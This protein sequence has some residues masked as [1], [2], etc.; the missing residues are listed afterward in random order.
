MENLF[1]KITAILIFQL[2]VI[3]I[4]SQS[5]DTLDK[6]YTRYYYHDGELRSEGVIE[7]GKPNGY[8]KSYYQNKVVKSEG[9]RINFKLEGLWVFY[10]IDGDTIEKINYHRDKKNGYDFKYQ[11][12][13]IDG[14]KT[15]ILKSKE[16]FVKDKKQNK[17]Y[18]Y[19]DDGS[20]YQIVNYKNNFKNG[21]TREFDKNGNI[22][23]VYTYKNGILIKKENINRF[24]HNG[25]K[26]GLW[27]DYFSNDRIKYEATYL[28]DKLHGYYKEWNIKGQLIKNVKY[29]NGEIVIDNSKKKEKLKIKKRYYDNGKIKYKGSYRDTIPVGIHRKYDESGKIAASDIY[30]DFGNLISNGIVDDEGIY[31]GKF[32]NYYLSGEKKSEGNYLKGLKDGKWIFYYKSGEIEQEGYFRKGKID[33]EWNWYYKNG[34]VKRQEHYIDGREDGLCIEYSKDG[35]ILEKGEYQEGLKEGEWVNNVGEHVEKGN[36]KFGLRDGRWE[37]Y[38]PNGKLKF[39]GNFLQGNEDGKHKW[40]YPDGRLKEEKYYVFGSREKIWKYFNPD[41]SLFMSVTYRN[42]KEIKI[43][44]KRIEKEENKSKQ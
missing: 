2:I 32:V 36:Y 7:K 23:S 11:Y 44:G 41:G 38:Y 13:D 24:D 6:G 16:L 31:H 29:F 20:I 39:E 14:K 17:S 15:G 35:E 30:D 43:N 1:K 27:R 25:K 4:F 42:N 40:Y 3:N 10:D 22:I 19:N 12:K 37:Y 5:I 21:L 26:Q 18:Y 28:N 34:N 8:W 33:G 9:N